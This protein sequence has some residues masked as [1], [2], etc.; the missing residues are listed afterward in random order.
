MKLE[1]KE[2]NLIT[3]SIKEYVKEKESQPII[4]GFELSKDIQ[5]EI[6]ILSAQALKD[7]ED[8]EKRIAKALEPVE[9]ATQEL[10]D[11]TKKK[12]EEAA[13]KSAA[14]SESYLNENFDGR[15]TKQEDSYVVQCQG[16]KDLRQLI[17]EA[18][19]NDI[20]YRFDKL[21]EGEYKYNFIYTLPEVLEEGMEDKVKRT[22]VEFTK[23]KGQIICNKG[24]QQEEVEKLLK[25]KGYQVE[26]LPGKAGSV[27][28]KYCKNCNES[29]E[30]TTEDTR[31]G[32]KDDEYLVIPGNRTGYGIDQV[33]DMTCTV[34]ELKTA[35][36]DYDDNLKVV[37]SNDNEYTFG[38]FNPEEWYRKI[39]VDKKEENTEE[40]VDESAEFLREDG[41]AEVTE[42]KEETSTQET[43][44]ESFDL[45]GTLKNYVPYDNAVSIWNDITNANK[46]DEFA[47]VLEDLY[48]S[49]MTIEEL[50]D[51]LSTKDEIVRTLLDLEKAETKEE[52][53][54][55]EPVFTEVSKEIE[56]ED[57]DNVEDIKAL[58][59]KEENPEEIKKD[60]EKY[61]SSETGYDEEDIDEDDTSD[62]DALVK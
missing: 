51:F 19:A 12:K 36:E 29:Y 61:L 23:E 30:D 28:I 43:L 9:K 20:K 52:V 40:K 41:K 22:T 57:D 44:T 5:V 35:L 56:D 3:E 59:D 24:S 26:V 11:D 50:N 25:D 46:I 1:K 53:T 21:L 32:E 2:T 31:D 42:S 18:K 16:R 37:I 48:P 34:G 38:Y 54:I 47:D 6:P 15:W 60:A 62:I 10:V 45:K 7:I 4:E 55:E 58:L 13:K 27:N 49:G 8:N 33:E 14:L 39:I 17:A